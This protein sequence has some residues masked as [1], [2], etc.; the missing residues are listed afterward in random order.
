MAPKSKRNYTS[1][2]A[3]STLMMKWMKMND[4]FLTHSQYYCVT[5]RITMTLLNPPS[6]QGHMS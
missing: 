3:K 2:C 1:F 6:A 4:Y 5:R